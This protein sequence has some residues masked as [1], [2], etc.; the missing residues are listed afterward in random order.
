VA[1]PRWR[2][3]S[4]WNAYNVLVE[5]VARGNL[6]TTALASLDHVPAGYAAPTATSPT[7]ADM[8]RPTITGK[9]TPNATIRVKNASNTTIIDT[10]A[11]SAGNWSKVP[12]ADLT[13]G[14]NALTVTQIVNPGGHADTINVGITVS[15]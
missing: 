8:P 6:L 15:K 5:Q 14:T 13:T 3:L 11:D 10:R 9:A 7:T 12:T 4:A 2:R 1:C